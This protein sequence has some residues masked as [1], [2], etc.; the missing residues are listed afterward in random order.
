MCEIKLRLSKKKKKKWFEKVCCNKRDF[1]LL[2]N[3]YLT[4]R[5]SSQFISKFVI[6]CILYKAD[7][8]YIKKLFVIKAK[9]DVNEYLWWK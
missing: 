8:K 7:K 2:T 3:V 4:I 6:F 5:H 9:Q 1:V